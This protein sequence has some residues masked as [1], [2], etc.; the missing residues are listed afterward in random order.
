MSITK[1][2][3]QKK[4]TNKILVHWC[5][6]KGWHEHSD[7]ILTAKEIERKER[8]AASLEWVN[9][10]CTEN[11]DLINIY[12][13]I[14]SKCVLMLISF[15]YPMHLFNIYAMSVCVCVSS[16]VDSAVRTSEMVSFL[17]W[18]F[19]M[20][21]NL[22]IQNVWQCQLQKPITFYLRWNFERINMKSRRDFPNFRCSFRL[23]RG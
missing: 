22:S 20:F 23:I 5:L 16:V 1:H 3:L 9:M 13:E 14:M 11:D 12:S 2:E 10:K 7:K 15:G 21:V 19:E 6:G 4:K 8:P 18:T 17:R